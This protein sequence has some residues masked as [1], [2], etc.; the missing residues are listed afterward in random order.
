MR[1]LPFSDETGRNGIRRG[2]GR[3][4]D[5]EERREGNLQ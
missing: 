1:G 3:E 4:R 5:W 2:E